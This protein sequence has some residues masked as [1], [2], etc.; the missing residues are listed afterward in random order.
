MELKFSDLRENV[1]VRCR[2]YVRSDAEV[3]ERAE[4]SLVRRTEVAPA[5]RTPEIYTPTCMPDSNRSRSDAVK[6]FART[7]TSAASG[8]SS[9]APA[10]PVMNTKRVEDN[11]P[12]WR[13]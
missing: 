3:P 8:M 9:I 7:E 10:S 11:A 4:L 1:R 2:C 13:R 5:I 6:G 12:L